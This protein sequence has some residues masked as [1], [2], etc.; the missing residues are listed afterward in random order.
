MKQLQ[1]QWKNTKLIIGNFNAK[2]GKKNESNEN[3]IGTFGYGS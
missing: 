3:N 2:L 1:N